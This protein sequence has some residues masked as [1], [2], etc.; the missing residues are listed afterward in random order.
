MAPGVMNTTATSYANVDAT[1]LGGELTAVATLVDQLFLS[2]D[3]SWVR[4]SQAAD[5]ALNITSSHLQEMPPLRGRAA[6]RWDNG[7]FFAEAEGAFSAA[8][9]RVDTDVGEQ[10]MPEW[11]IAN[12][13]A[14]ANV[15]SFTLTIGVGNLFDRQYYESLS[16]VRDPYRSGV[17]VPEPGRTVFANLGWRY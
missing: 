15:A 12:L 14:G 16:Y 13:K 6:L 4:G 8:Q 7:R 3:V 2:G 5:P 11:G 10:S 1:L 17:R 9:N